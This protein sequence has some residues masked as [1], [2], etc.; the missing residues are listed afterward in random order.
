MV[1]GLNL[2]GKVY[3]FK[4][5]LGEGDDEVGGSQPSGTVLQDGVQLRI[6]SQKPT[7]ALLEQGVESI[8][9]YTGVIA[10]YTID[11]LNNQEIEVTAPSNSPYYGKFFRILGDPQR[12][13][14]SPSD[15][16]GFLMVTMRRVEK[17]RTI[18]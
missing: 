2:I 3:D 8:D 13:S 10:N 14:T 17:S 1:A 12:S 15:S 11:I 4:Y 18:Q 5:N 6:A 16:R 7:R 9:L